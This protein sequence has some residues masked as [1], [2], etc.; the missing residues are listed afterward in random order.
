MRI[1][2]IAIKVDDLESAGEFYETVLG[3]R[4]V[5]QGKTRDHFSRHMTD[6][7]ID[8]A[9]IKYDSE[10]TSEEA[11]AAGRGP[12]IHHVGFEVDDVKAN[13]DNLRRR[14]CEVISGPGVVPIKFRI[15]G[16][17]IAEFAPRGHFRIE[18]T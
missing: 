8:I 13:A 15:P 14:G 18:R 16:G 9:L 1:A 7:N 10:E 3:F 11:R 6:G 12:C 5:R 17:T 4:D 2:H